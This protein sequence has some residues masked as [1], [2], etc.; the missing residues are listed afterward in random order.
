MYVCTCIYMNLRI[1]NTC[2]CRYTYT[3]TVCSY[4]FTYVRIIHTNYQV[5]V[6]AHT[7]VHVRTRTHAHTHTHTHT[8]S[9]SLSK[10]QHHTCTYIPNTFGG[11][12][13]DT[14]HF[15]ILYSHVYTLPAA[16]GVWFH[17]AMVTTEL[18]NSTKYSLS[19][20]GSELLMLLWQLLSLT[21]D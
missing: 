13:Y 15:D 8:L 18:T 21:L 14:I 5:Y 9:L 20:T 2:T 1:F 12:M 16:S 7:Y 3:Y 19:H 4:K 17:I 10:S 11:T 6:F